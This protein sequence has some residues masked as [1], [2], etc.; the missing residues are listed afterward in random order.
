MS[1]KIVT[2][3][4]LQKMIDENQGTDFLVHLV[5]RAL[6]ILFERQ[7]NAEQSSNTTNEHNTI[8]FTGADGYSGCLTA[9]SYLKSKR[10]ADWQ[11]E[12]W[13]GKNKNGFSRIVKYHRQL[14]EAA[15]EKKAKQNG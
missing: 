12:K 7:T 3:E 13:V 14:N 11:L 15:I 2:R 10:L 1:E 6:V 9:K 4:S 8:G 5:G